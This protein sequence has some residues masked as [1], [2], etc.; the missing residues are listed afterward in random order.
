MFPNCPWNRERGT[1]TLSS[2][3]S[4]LPDSQ[5]ELLE[6]QEEEMEE[7]VTPPAHFSSSPD[8]A[9]MTPPPTSADDC[10]QF[11]ELFCRIVDSLQIPLEEVR[12]QKHKLLDILHTSILTK[13]ALLINEGLLNPAKVNW[14][15]PASIPS[16]CKRVDMEFLFPPYSK[17]S[18]KCSA[19]EGVTTPF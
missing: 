18:R 17:F 6:E 16:T 10:K 1:Y 8:Q 4:R 15:T 12:E 13:I 7:L 14:Q 5:P 3:V 9:I 2:S 19:R 11:Q